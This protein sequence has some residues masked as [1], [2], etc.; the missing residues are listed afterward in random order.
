MAAAQ[1]LAMEQAKPIWG[2]MKD[3]DKA[4]YVRMA[5]GAPST[6]HPCSVP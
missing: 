2:K 6:A 3:D 1:K 4:D 5:E